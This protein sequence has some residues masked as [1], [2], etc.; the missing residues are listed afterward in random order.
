MSSCVPAQAEQS[1]GVAPSTLTQEHVVSRPDNLPSTQ[2]LCSVQPQHRQAGPSFFRR[3]PTGGISA[4]RNRGMCRPPRR[5]RLCK[6]P[7]LQGGVVQDSPSAFPRSRWWSC[8]RSGTRA[9]LLIG[10]SPFTV[11]RRVA[12][13]EHAKRAK[14][15]EPQ[16]DSL[17]VQYSA[18]SII[19][20]VFAVRSRNGRHQLLLRLR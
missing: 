15:K 14:S 3:G 7:A 4:A 5:R 12:A 9:R 16:N 6:L 20:Q 18:T 10:T 19:V 1:G 17:S 2:A 8:G 13:I 11:T